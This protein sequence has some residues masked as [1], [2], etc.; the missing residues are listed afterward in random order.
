MLYTVDDLMSIVYANESFV[1]F[2]AIFTYFWGFCQY[3]D[4]MY[5]QIKHKEC[6]FYFWMHCWYFG[7]DITFSFLFNQWWNEIGFW[8]FKVLNIG[9]MIFVLIEFVSIY[10]AVTYEA[11]W[12]WGKY[13]VSGKVPSKKWAWVMAISGYA[14]GTV[15]FV[16][17]R[18]VIGDPCCFF[19]MM[20]TNVTLALC[21]RF[22]VQ[23]RKYTRKGAKFLGW[24]T[25][26]G[27]IFTFS[28]P[29]VGFFATVMPFL[30][31]PFYYIVGVLCVITSI[32]HIYLTY[33][34]PKYED[35]IQLP[36]VQAK[37]ARE[38]K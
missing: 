30:N 19:L 17:I 4:S 6:P 31:T 23:E 33:H 13:F 32:R 10:Y 15:L 35:Y 11:D 38:G 28:P 12:N 3:L 7:H 29:G 18:K 20:S 16:C 22:N 2:A 25:L 21:V 5:Q 24:V 14:I 27:T 9:C 37:L 8:L 1:V 36:E 34:L 26:L